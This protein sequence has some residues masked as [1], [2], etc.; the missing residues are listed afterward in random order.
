VSTVSVDALMG[1][2]TNAAADRLTDE[3]RDAVVASAAEAGAALEAVA[4][5]PRGAT[6]IAS[7]ATAVTA[8]FA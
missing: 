6:A 4:G 7:H 3:T 5:H 2:M 1:M 8:L